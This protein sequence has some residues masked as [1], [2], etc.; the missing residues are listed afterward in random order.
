MSNELPIAGL[1]F[2]EIKSNFIEYLK[3]DQFYKD[4]NFQGSGINALINIL[5]YNTHYIGYYVKMALNESFIDS[6]TK[7]NTLMSK[8][9]LNGY[10]PKGKKCARA[11]V[12]LQVSMEPNQEPPTK[13]LIVPRGSSF[14]G[15]NSSS[16]T[17][18]FYVLDDQ[19][20][21]KDMVTST[22]T[23]VRYKSKEF[24]VYEGTQHTWRFV[25]DKTVNN[26]RFIIE[27][28]DVDISTIRVDV[29][30]TKNST[31]KTEY[32]LAANIFEVTPK[33]TVFYISANDRGLYEIFFGNNQFGADVSHG[34]MIHVYYI[35]SHGTGGNGCSSMVYQKPPENISRYT[36][37]NYS[38]FTTE[39]ISPSSGGCDEETI[40]ELRFNIPGHFRHQNRTVVDNDYRSLLLSEYRN[41]DSVNVWGGEKSYYRDYNTVYVSIKPKIGL[42]LNGAAKA[43]IEALLERYGVVNKQV[44]LVDPEYLRL[45]VDFQVKYKPQTT[46]MSIGEIERRVLELAESYNQTMLDR[47]EAG[48]SEVDFLDY[49]R[50]E[51]PAIHR[52]YTTKTMTKDCI[53]QYKT[54]TEHVILFGNAIVPGTIKS[55][56]IEYGKRLCTIEDD[57]AGSMW[58]MS[59]GEK[60][61]V[62]RIG[63]VDYSGIVRITMNID[64]K[65]EVDYG[66]SGL[67]SITATP[68]KP[69]ID[70]YL[71]NIVIIDRTSAGVTYA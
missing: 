25:V 9:K 27:D 7:R 15:S 70:T 59:N 37:G 63:S 46:S 21:Y 3:G 36:T 40:E 57:G 58:I 6:A 22:P 30:P 29:Y 16:D 33:S 62:N 65:T 47:F 23:V 38:I 28:P 53:I 4:Y 48:L 20:I 35:S 69:D 67:I 56:T 11:G 71:N 45:S 51:I 39:V 52:I 54:N 34:N 50:S 41:I 42:S 8:A 55:T 43:E 12:T 24:T 68:A 19:V 17:R 26:Q 66:Q 1:D 13:G 32:L 18:S 64:F 10:T 44:K 49:I 14:S 61:I 31:E 2:S 5:A 60:V